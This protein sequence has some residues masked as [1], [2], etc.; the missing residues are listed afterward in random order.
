[1]YPRTSISPREDSHGGFA[2][3]DDR[4]ES[5]DAARADLG[6]EAPGEQPLTRPGG[7]TIP[8]S[9][10]GPRLLR[11]LVVDDNRDAADTLAILVKIW[12][13]DA[14]R[15]YDGAAALESAAADPPD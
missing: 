2:M 4:W 1:M 8:P 3:S 9:L 6:A 14:R 13:H 12:G 10:A 7:G 15:A 11:V 5:A